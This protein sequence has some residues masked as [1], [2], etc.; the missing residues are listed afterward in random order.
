MEKNSFMAIFDYLND[1]LI[2]YCVLRNYINLPDKFSN[3][4]D[5]LVRNP[6]SMLLQNH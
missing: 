5:I 3:D 4:I 2:N 6:I 1:S